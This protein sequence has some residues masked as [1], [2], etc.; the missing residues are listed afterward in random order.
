MS[1]NGNGDNKIDATQKTTA[2]NLESSTFNNPPSTHRRVTT[3]THYS[4]IYTLPLDFQ[5]NCS[6]ICTGGLHIL[7]V[8]SSGEPI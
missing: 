7:E 5:Q 1:D 8:G 6:E 3:S 4:L 2:M